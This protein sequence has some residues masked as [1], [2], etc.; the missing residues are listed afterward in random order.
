[1][2]ENKPFKGNILHTKMF[3]R[4]LSTEEINLEHKKCVIRAFPDLKDTEPDEI[5]QVYQFIDDIKTLKE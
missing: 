3:N 1:M 4:Q 5:K 2:N